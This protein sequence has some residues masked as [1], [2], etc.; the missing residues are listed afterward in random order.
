MLEFEKLIFNFV[1]R[2]KMSLFKRWRLVLEINI[3]VGCVIP[4]SKGHYA[5]TIFR[6]VFKTVIHIVTNSGLKRLF[7]CTPTV[8]RKNITVVSKLLTRIENMEVW[9]HSSHFIISNNLLK[10]NSSQKPLVHL[11]LTHFYVI[12]FTSQ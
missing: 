3:K 12:K 4:N 5:L 6:N 2:S 10:S 8:H 1:K 9:A 11:F 7:D